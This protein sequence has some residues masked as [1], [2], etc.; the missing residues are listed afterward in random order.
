MSK[1][2]KTKTT[3]PIFDF[4]IIGGGFAGLATAYFLAQSGRSGIILEK[5]DHIAAHASGKNAGMFRQ[6]HSDLL[7]FE[8]ANRSR[9]FF[10]HP[11]RQ[12]LFAER[13]SI[14]LTHEAKG[15]EPLVDYPTP[16]G[17][18]GTSERLTRHEALQRLPYLQNCNFRASY[19]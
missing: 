8:L 6:L 18:W 13:G 2:Q 4:A 5:E 1:D 9:H 15:Q 16:M 14:L 10:A 19:Q 17:K 7:V 11:E 12:N 3:A